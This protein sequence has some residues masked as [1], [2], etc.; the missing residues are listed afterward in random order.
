MVLDMP[1]ENRQCHTDH[2]KISFSGIALYCVEKFAI[3]AVIPC[4]QLMTV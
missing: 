4:Y 2:I 1:S 3:L